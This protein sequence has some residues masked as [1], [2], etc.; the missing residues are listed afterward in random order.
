MYRINMLESMDIHHLER[1][2]LKMRM[3]ILIKR[4]KIGAL[5]EES[6]LD[7]RVC[8]MTNLKL[9]ANT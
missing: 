6:S 4:E 8:V 2:S 1:T 7:V 9:I 3:L 5:D